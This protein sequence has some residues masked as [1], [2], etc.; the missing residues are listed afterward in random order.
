MNIDKLFSGVKNHPESEIQISKGTYSFFK[1]RYFAAMKTFSNYITE[2]NG[3]ITLISVFISLM[4]WII[5]KTI[6]IYFSLNAG[7]EISIL[8]I[9]RMEIVIMIIIVITGLI[10]SNVLGKNIHSRIIAERELIKSREL[11]N[12][13]QKISKTGGWKWLVKQQ[14]MFWTDEMYRIHG[15]QPGDTEPG[16]PEHI[17]KSLAC[18]S[19]Y[20][21][22]EIMDAFYKCI[23]HGTPFTIEA[24]LTSA[25]NEKKWV[26]ISAEANY[27]ENGNIAEVIGNV[28]D[29]SDRKEKE[30]LWK[31][32]ASVKKSAEFKQIFLAKMSHEIRTSLTG[33]IGM[34][35]LLSKTPLSIGQEEFITSLENST[36]NLRKIIN[37]ILDY[38]KIEA[39]K[40]TLKPEEFHFCTLFSNTEKVFN[41]I[42]HKPVKIKT[43]VDDRIPSFIR[44]DR[45][46]INQVI[47][48]LLSNAVKHTEHGTI[49]IKAKPEYWMDN[50]NLVVRIEVNDTGV[51]ISREKQKDLF[52]PFSQINESGK[53][54]L[55]DAD[56]E[57]TGLGLIICAELAQLMGGEIGVKSEPGKGSTFWFT[58]MAQKIKSSHNGTDSIKKQATQTNLL[59]NNLEILLVDDKKVNRQ[60]IRL[61]LSSLGHNITL[62][63]NGQEAVDL[64][65]PGKYHLILMDIRMPVMDG[66]TATKI[67]K[68]KYQKL[69][70]VVGLSANAFEG[71]RE[72]YIQLGMD[73]YL[74][75]PLDI[76]DF[77]NMIDKLQIN[78]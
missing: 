54:W 66:V 77:E 59:K 60:V 3:K 70:P 53:S 31:E 13:T 64:Y 2:G 27:D 65:Q 17:Q 47:N 10:A 41:S 72:K 58:F 44:A 38:S 48:N 35:D 24:M 67:L 43:L 6:H 76:K 68:E 19:T 8:K 26:V 22:F 7:T 34:V 1:G 61:L 75:K 23:T 52:K 39:G 18:F 25:K 21:S 36:H 9:S 63:T 4:L 69:P 14:K 33:V 11:L 20:D 45:H 37:E 62:A 32:I 56:Q 30:S 78:A 5:I 46:R 74:T 57:G 12:S 71:D 16:S 29:I 40:L 50:E 51:G 42:C 55:E 28:M 73:E 49:S 15:Y